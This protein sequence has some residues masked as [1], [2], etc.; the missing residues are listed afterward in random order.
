MEGGGVVKLPE[1]IFQDVFRQ[2]ESVSELNLKKGDIYGIALVDPGDPDASKIRI[3][4]SSGIKALRK[5]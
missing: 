3:K 5:Y 4:T 2:F 1:L